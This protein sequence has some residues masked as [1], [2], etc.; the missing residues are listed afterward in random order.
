MS[1]QHSIRIDLG[2][3]DCHQLYISPTQGP[4]LKLGW[5]WADVIKWAYLL[6]SR[7]FQPSGP[8]STDHKTP[9]GSIAVAI[10]R[11]RSCHVAPRNPHPSN[12]PSSYLQP[13]FPS[14][15]SSIRPSPDREAALQREGVATF[16]S[17]ASEFNCL[18]SLCLV[19]SPADL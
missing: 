3:K 1:L 2:G 5:S 16:P 12:K 10:D 9:L 11:S 13:P 17:K 14:P 4:Y 18:S 15:P 7:H 19:A 6:A 8:R